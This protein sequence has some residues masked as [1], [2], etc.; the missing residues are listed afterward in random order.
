[1]RIC[2]FSWIP[3]E[4]LGARNNDTPRLPLDSN[5]ITA[6]RATTAAHATVPTSTTRASTAIGATRATSATK[7]YSIAGSL[8]QTYKKRITGG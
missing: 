2:N 1:M 8:K 7:C 3:T 4:L 6:T 5:A